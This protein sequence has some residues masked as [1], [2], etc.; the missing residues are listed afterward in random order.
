MPVPQYLENI[1]IAMAA[2]GMNARQIESLVGSGKLNGLTSSMKALA[3]PDLVA[4]L[5]TV[6]DHLPANAGIMPRP[7]RPIINALSDFFSR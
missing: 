6:N 1:T 4:L 7:Y 5:Q 3:H 2:A